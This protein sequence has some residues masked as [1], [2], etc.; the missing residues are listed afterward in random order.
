MH[1]TKLICPRLWLKLH[2]TV[3]D[4]RRYKTEKHRVEDSAAKAEA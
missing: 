1:Y 3:V 2:H 4:Q